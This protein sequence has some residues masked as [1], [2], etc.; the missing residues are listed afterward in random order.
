M[1]LKKIAILGLLGVSSAAMNGLKNTNW[2]LFDTP[3]TLKSNTGSDINDSSVIGSYGGYACYRSG[4]YVFP[5][6]F[7]DYTSTPECAR[8]TTGGRAFYAETSS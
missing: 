6:Q 7:I 4:G 2:P 3:I 1:N 5:A 8:G